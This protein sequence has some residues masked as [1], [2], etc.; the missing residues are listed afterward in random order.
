MHIAHFTN[1]YHPVVSGVV[2]SVSA[3]RKALTEL[4]HNVF[5]FAQ[6][7]G[8]HHDEE[9]FIFRYPAIKLPLRV[10]FPATIPISPFVDKLLPSLK[11]DVIHSHH[12]VLIGQAAVSKAEE[13]NLPLVFTF[14]T[15]YRDY[16]HYFPLPQE[17]VQ[18][19]VKDAIESWLA[20][21]MGKCHHIV[22]PS[23]SMRQ[24]LVE[25]YGLEDR[26]TAIPT[27]IDLR[28][29]QDADGSAIRAQRGWGDD[30][31]L[32]SVGRLALE[33]NI[34]TLL[35][36]CAQVMRT[37]EDVRLV[38]IGDG[39]AWDSLHQS[40]R[41]LGIAE[42]V[43][44]TGKIPFEEVP[45]YLKAA[46]LFVFASVTE[47]QGLVTMEAF[48][49][50]LPVVAV[51]GTGTRDVVG[52]EN[53]GLLTENDGAALGEA[54][55]RILGDETLLSS[56]KQAAVEK[57]RTLDIIHVAKQLQDVYSQAIDDKNAGRKVIVGKQKKLF[58]SLDIKLP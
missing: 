51:D 9:P 11:L 57:A 53:E 47:T 6:D 44:F 14:H 27:G 25:E 17:I 20:D 34:K 21:Y 23:E 29:Y 36:A 12:P 26:L 56:Y 5:V 24:I 48:A 18:E 10:D 37:N 52:H 35:N 7:T 22:V 13:L 19:F 1:T 55:Q 54:I 4:G 16:T 31:V 38:L 28:P 39:P 43:E 8:Q 3:F 15:R 49:A 30:R 33:K 46:D 41:Q 2:R 50:G 45:A 42:R 32:I 40:T 58:K